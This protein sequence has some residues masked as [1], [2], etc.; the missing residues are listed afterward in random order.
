MRPRLAT[1]AAACAGVLLA[2]AAAELEKSPAQLALSAG[3]GA[4]SGSGAGAPGPLAA[5]LGSIEVEL[6]PRTEGPLTLQSLTCG[7]LAL[8]QLGAQSP[9]KSSTELALTLG[10]LSGSCSGHW[11]LKGGG[12]AHPLDAALLPASALDVTVAVLGTADPRIASCRATIAI[13]DIKPAPIA[14][15]KKLLQDG[16][17]DVVCLALRTTGRT[18][19]ATLLRDFD[20]GVAPY[21]PG[22]PR[23]PTIAAKQQLGGLREAGWVDWGQS[24]WLA[25]ADYALND[26]L[27][28]PTLNALTAPTGPPPSHLDPA[29]PGS[30]LTRASANFRRR[31]ALCGGEE[32]AAAEHNGGEHQVIH[33][34]GAEGL[35]RRGPAG[36]CRLFLGPGLRLGARWNRLVETVKTRKKWGKTGGKWARYSLKRVKEGS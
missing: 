34:I 35:D 19:L 24:G 4:E 20:T 12:A 21:L 17:E 8:R 7:G 30:A 36:P 23:S 10:G 6:P 32:P 25:I 26:A 27:S 31:G 28:L 5:W 3:A 14:G 11:A 2:V 33:P 18:L 29:N 13:G 16:L 15:L 9:A 1:V 22:A